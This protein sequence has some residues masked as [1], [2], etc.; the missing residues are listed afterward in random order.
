MAFL[1]ASAARNNMVS[2]ISGRG[3]PI[4]VANR[5]MKRSDTLSESRA[6]RI[7]NTALLTATAFCRG[8]R[9]RLLNGCPVSSCFR[10][11]GCRLERMTR[12]MSSRNCRLSR[13]YS[14]VSVLLPSISARL[15]ISCMRACASFADLRWVLSGNPPADSHFRSSSRSRSNIFGIKRRFRSSWS[16]E[17]FRTVARLCVCFKRSEKDI[18]EACARPRGIVRSSFFTILARNSLRSNGS[19]TILEVN[20]PSRDPPQSSKIFERIR[21][22][23]L[24]AKVGTSGRTR[25]AAGLDA[26]GRRV[27]L[28]FRLRLL[29]RPLRFRLLAIGNSN[30][31]ISVTFRPLAYHPVKAAGDRWDEPKIQDGIRGA[32]AR[33]S[34]KSNGE[35]R[36]A[37]HRSS[38]EPEHGFIPVLILGYSRRPW[39]GACLFSGSLASRILGR[40]RC[41]FEGLG[42]R[43]LGMYMCIDGTIS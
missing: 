30:P 5:W 6:R 7:R 32:Y 24:K 34:G 25:A 33:F 35:G 20:S 39:D 42:N 31:S 18:R 36:A 27:R 12:I 21:E 26:F 23:G 14:S 4:S 3:S 10:F 13:R 2:A 19:A 37:R 15:S 29:G 9:L 8:W 38:G 1:N 40:W 17:S 22:T 28:A 43:G 41:L 11:P 16:V